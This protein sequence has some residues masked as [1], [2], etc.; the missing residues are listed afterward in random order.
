MVQ[1]WAS[2]SYLL[3]LIRCLI[4]ECPREYNPPSSAMSWKAKRILKDSLLLDY[5]GSVLHS[6]STNR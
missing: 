6:H 2:K 5:E 3:G 1:P 4:F